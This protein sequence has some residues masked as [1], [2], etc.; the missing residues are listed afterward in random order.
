VG[1]C[2][3]E[4]QRYGEARSALE[5]AVERFPDSTAAR[6]ASQRLDRMRAERR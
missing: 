6:L 3:Y 1:F 2:Q 5:T 4:L